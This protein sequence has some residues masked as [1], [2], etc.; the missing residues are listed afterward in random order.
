MSADDS[1]TNTKVQRKIMVRPGG[2]RHQLTDYV[3]C[4]D[5]VDVSTHIDLDSKERNCC[6]RKVFLI[7]LPP[8]APS[9]RNMCRTL[10][11]YPTTQ[12]SHRVPVQYACVRGS[13]SLPGG[14]RAPLLVFTAPLLRRCILRYAAW[15]CFRSASFV[16]LPN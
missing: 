4:K 5:D 3:R 12:C 13:S 2:V 10:T 8:V 1:L 15:S 14:R 9:Q 6:L 11:L 16:A 7:A